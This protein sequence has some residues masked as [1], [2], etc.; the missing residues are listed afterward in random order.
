MCQG[1][2]HNGVCLYWKGVK[3]INDVVAMVESSTAALRVLDHETRG[4]HG[5]RPVMRSTASDG[6]MRLKKP[7]A[8]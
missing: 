3:E 8:G 2:M 1:Q 4:T 5:R 6:E 7:S